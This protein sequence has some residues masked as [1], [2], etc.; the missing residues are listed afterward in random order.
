MVQAQPDSAMRRQVEAQS[1]ACRS[2]AIAMQARAD[3]YG[4]FLRHERT[5][6]QGWIEQLNA[7]AD[8]LTAAAAE[9][10]FGQV[11]FLTRAARALAIPLVGVGSF[12]GGFIGGV[13]QG[14]GTSSFDQHFGDAGQVAECAEALVATSDEAEALLDEGGWNADYVFGRAMARFK[15]SE[16]EA[17]KGLQRTFGIPATRFIE[18]ER[19][20]APPTD[21]ELSIVEGTA[22]RNQD[23]S[24]AW[25]DLLAAVEALQRHRA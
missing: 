20:S 22:R 11:R 25:R 1:G 16:K 19:A 12:A 10:E 13:G 23:L 9:G 4:F 5:V 7:I 3:G 21:T 8:A 15:A 14:Y 6:V 18:F 2:L 24:Q 17:Y